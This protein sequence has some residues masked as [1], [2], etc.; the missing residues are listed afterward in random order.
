MKVLVLDTETTGIGKLDEIIQLAYVEL[1]SF[2]HIFEPFGSIYTSTQNNGTDIKYRPSV[3]IHPE[4]AK[5]NGIKF[6]QLLKCPPSKQLN[7]TDL[8]DVD[9]IIGHNISFDKR[10]LLQCI[11]E[12]KQDLFDK[13]KFVC[14][15]AL[16]KALDKNLDIGFLNHKLDTLVNHFFTDD[17]EV[18]T[19]LLTETHDALR[20]VIKTILVLGKLCKY[21]P[22][23]DSIESLDLFLSSLKA[24]KK[25]N[26]KHQ[27]LLARLT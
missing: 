8:I 14:T 12:D 5:V 18:K 22:A 3:P 2:Q 11:P 15:M 27:M 17:V 13:T 7:Y 6:I 9:Y 4:A 21:I 16:S 10:M 25:E 20:D 19:T 23:V 26:K 1:Q 24:I